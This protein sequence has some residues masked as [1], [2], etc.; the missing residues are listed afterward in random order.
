M[1]LLL[2]EASRDQLQYLK[3][4]STVAFMLRILKR[5]VN[6]TGK[7]PCLRRNRHRSA[8]LLSEKFLK[9]EAAEFN[10]VE[11]DLTELGDN[12]NLKEFSTRLKG[13]SSRL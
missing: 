11:V 4:R 3:F 8:P 2:Q 6:T 12:F 9:W 10:G 1:Q 13:R 5:F 7:G